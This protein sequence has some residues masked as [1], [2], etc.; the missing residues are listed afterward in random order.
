[1]AKSLGITR[2]LAAST[3]WRAGATSRPCFEHDRAYAAV[4]NRRRFVATPPFEEISAPTA[5]CS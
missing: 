4:I 5:N 2:E 1:M 3:R